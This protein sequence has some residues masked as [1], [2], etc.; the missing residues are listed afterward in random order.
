MMGTRGTAL[1]SHADCVIECLLKCVDL[2]NKTAAGYAAKVCMYAYHVRMLIMYI[3]LS[4]TYAYHVC[5]LI[6]YVCLS[7]TYAYHVRMLI[8]CTQSTITTKSLKLYSLI[9]QSLTTV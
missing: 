2:K 1:L 4:C 3:C 5:M 8:M 6:M 9:R 7:C